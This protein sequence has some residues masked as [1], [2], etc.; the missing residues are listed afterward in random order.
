MSAMHKIA[1]LGDRRSLLMYRS[2]GFSLFMPQ[3]ENDV[4]RIIEQLREDEYAIAFVTEQV[5]KM[6]QQTIMDYDRTF[7]PALIVLPGYGED[8][9]A[10]MSR[11]SELVENAIGMKL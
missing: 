5:F 6:A 2:A 7:T 3:D 1:F 9:Q 4:R 8:G 10:G 11:L